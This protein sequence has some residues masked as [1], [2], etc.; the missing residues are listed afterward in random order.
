M[1]ELCAKVDVLTEKSQGKESVGVET[2]QPATDYERVDEETL[3]NDNVPALCI[4]DESLGFFN[5]AAPDLRGVLA[6][7]RDFI[8]RDM[9]NDFD[10]SGMNV[11]YPE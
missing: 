7:S 11:G 10:S 8:T 9:Y 1:G 5:L 6:Q 2:M 3:M 4:M